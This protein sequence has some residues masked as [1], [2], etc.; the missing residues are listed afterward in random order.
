MHTT[1]THTH[2]THMHA[3]SHISLVL[4]RLDSDEDDNKNDTDNKHDGDDHHLPIL[5]LVLLS[6]LEMFESGLHTSPCLLDVIV[7][8]VQNRPLITDRLSQDND[9]TQRTLQN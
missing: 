7:N 9:P 1:R 6:F 2:H 5:L 8:P 4:A 3:L